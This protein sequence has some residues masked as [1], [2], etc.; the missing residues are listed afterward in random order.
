MDLLQWQCTVGFQPMLL[1]VLTLGLLFNLSM[2]EMNWYSVTF[3]VQALGWWYLINKVNWIDSRSF[4]DTHTR[5]SSFPALL[6]GCSRK[7]MQ[8]DLKFH[9]M[10]ISIT[11]HFLLYC[12][13]CKSSSNGRWNT[14]Q[15]QEHCTSAVELTAVK[16]VGHTVDSESIPPFEA[17]VF[18]EI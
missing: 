18:L 3:I 15:F 14:R 11:V 16:S 1:Y 17:T 2:T 9:C 8:G 12:T 4:S 7:F 10:P 6:S 5:P 13:R